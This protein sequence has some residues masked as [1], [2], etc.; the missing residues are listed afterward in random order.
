MCFRFGGELPH[1]ES[2]HRP[3]RAGSSSTRWP[4]GAAPTRRQWRDRA[5][6]TAR[7]SGAR[8][9][10][11]SP[12]PPM[13]SQVSYRQRKLKGADDTSQSGQDRKGLLTGAADPSSDPNAFVPVIVT[14]AEPASMADDGVFPAHRATPGQEAQRNYPGSLWSFGSGSEIKRITAG[15]KAR[16]DRSLPRFDLLAGP[17]PSRRYQFRKKKEYC[18]LS[19]VSHSVHWIGRFKSTLRP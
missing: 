12:P 1:A 15:V 14:V 2:G 6:E 4:V 10:R 5:G 18:S 11:P 3:H 16:S 8:L 9:A 17:S 7:G 13:C 19:A